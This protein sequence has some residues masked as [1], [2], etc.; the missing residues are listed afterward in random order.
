M[1]VYF[2]TVVRMAPPRKGGNLIR[3]N[4]DTKQIEARV[5]IYPENPEINDPNPRGNTRGGRGIALLNGSVIVGAYHTLKVFDRDLNHVRD[6]AHPLLVNLHE[7]FVSGPDR[8]LVS[9]T[10]IDAVLEIDLVSGQTVR[11][12]WPREEPAFQEA[13]GVSPLAIDKHADNR[14]Q[15]LSRA[16]MEDPSHLH[17]NAV[18]QWNRQ[19]FAFCHAIGAVLNLDTC[20]V[21]LCDPQLKGGHNLIVTDEE[22]LVNDTRG[23]NV[24]IY[25]RSTKALR[26]QLSL[27]SYD[28]V[29][30]ILAREMPAVQ[31]KR[32]ISEIKRT[33]AVRTLKDAPLVKQL[34]NGH[35]QGVLRKLG[36]THSAAAAAPLFVR[37]LD[38]DTEHVFVG[39]SPG[40]IAQINRITGELVDM[41]RFSDDVRICIH[42]LRIMK[43]ENH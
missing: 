18:T 38:M 24:R 30:D 9:C 4:W 35:L 32:R 27:D 17:I 8:L 43:V 26:Q 1:Q 42:G 29:R 2:S 37:G 12:Y 28:V 34:K 11:E 3:L 10:S 20:E 15:F 13:L 25:D 40:T 31:R 6:I 39:F 41:Y 36:L 22:I 23:H 5:P 7:T 21:E 19:T 14:L 33:K 16:Y